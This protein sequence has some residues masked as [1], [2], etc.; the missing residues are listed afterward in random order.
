V[1]QEANLQWRHE[2]TSCNLI[3]PWY[4]KPAL[5][6]LLKQDVKN[7]SVWEYGAGYSTIWYRLNAAQI[8]SVEHNEAWA[9]SMG[10]IFFPDKDSYLNSPSFL[11][12]D[13]DEFDL[14][15]VDGEWRDECVPIIKKFVKAGGYL[16]YD[17]YDQEGFTSAAGIDAML[18]GWT[19]QVFFQGNHSSW[20]TAVFTKP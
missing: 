9:T 2:D 5:E 20:K 11:I 4:V 1:I 13:D 10:A 15:V 17:N 14:V 19:K 16:I 12:E 7:W 6:W 8:I 18:E 3:L